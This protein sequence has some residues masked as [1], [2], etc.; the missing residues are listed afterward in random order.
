MA[1]MLVTVDVDH[2]VSLCVMQRLA[3]QGRISKGRLG[4]NDNDG[5]ENKHCKLEMVLHRVYEG[6]RGGQCD[7]RSEM[8]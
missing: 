3:D 5:E 4:M 8:S 1:N 7:C 6:D 2:P